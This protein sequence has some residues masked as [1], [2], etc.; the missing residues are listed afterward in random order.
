MASGLLAHAAGSFSD[1]ATIFEAIAAAAGKG[2]LANRLAG[3]GMGICEDR[4]GDFTTY[5]EDY[6]EHIQRYSLSF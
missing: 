3:V 5:H 4:D 2:T 6:A 1:I